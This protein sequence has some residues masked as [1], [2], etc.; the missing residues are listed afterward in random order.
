MPICLSTGIS[1]QTKNAIP[2]TPI[3][4]AIKPGRIIAS[5]V[6]TRGRDL[7]VRLIEL[8]VKRPCHWIP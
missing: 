5:A 7:V 4:I 1:A 6:A 2:A 8:L 3:G